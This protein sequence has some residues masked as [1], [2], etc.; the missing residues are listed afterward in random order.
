[1]FALNETE[2]ASIHAAFDAGGELAAAV[3]LR[4]LFPGISDLQKAREC[5]RTVLSWRRPESPA[6]ETPAES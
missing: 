5:A 6:S 4:R 3:E 2:I 1:M